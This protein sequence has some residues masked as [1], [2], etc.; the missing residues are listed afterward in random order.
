VKFIIWLLLAAAATALEPVTLPLVV[1][2]L[3]TRDG[4]IFEG[5]KITGHD[6]V[7]VKIIHSGGVA[8]VEFDRLPKELAERFPHDQA[9]AKEQLDKEAKREAAHDRAVDKVRD[10]KKTPAGEADDD[11]ADTD[12]TAVEGEPELQGDAAVKIASLNAYISRLEAGIN[13]ANETILDA[14]EKAA[15]YELTATTQ[16]RYRDGD[17]NTRTESVVNGSRLTR[18]AFQRKRAKREEEKIA[19]AQRLIANA[20]AQ[21]AALQDQT[22]Q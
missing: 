7:G 12:D 17:Y 9:A 14:N 4:K 10:E 3:K 19:Q 11:T 15:K 2:T 13:K 6:A 20:R 21:I 5:A 1:G 8:R 16:V 18:A 22:G